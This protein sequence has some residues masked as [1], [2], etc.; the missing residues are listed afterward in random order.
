M[1]IV[2]EISLVI[3]S[4]IINSVYTDAHIRS[5]L[6][7]E[8]VRYMFSKSTI[9]ISSPPL[10]WLLLFGMAYGNMKGCRILTDKGRRDFRRRLALWLSGI[11]AL[12]AIAIILFLTIAPHAIL[13]NISGELFP[14]SFSHSF[15]SI[16]PAIAL[17]VFTTYGIVTQRYRSMSQ[18]LQ[19][20]SSGIRSIAELVII[21]I[22]LCQIYLSLMFVIA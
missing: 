14:G 4:W 2:A 6:S 20:M 18:W 15:M 21:Y 5:L 9:T 16:L 19:S 13:S 10:V 1:L 17:C 7:S 12:F 8:A 3:I 22:F 11:V